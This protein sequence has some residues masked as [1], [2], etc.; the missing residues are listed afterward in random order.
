[1]LTFPLAGFDKEGLEGLLKISESSGNNKKPMNKAVTSKQNL[2]IVSDSKVANLFP[3][4]PGNI[5]VRLKYP[6]VNGTI[7]DFLLFRCVRTV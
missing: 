7:I 3:G 6:I 2:M 1:M 5:L 4:Q